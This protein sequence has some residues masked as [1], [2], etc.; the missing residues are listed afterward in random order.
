MKQ[1]KRICPSCHGSGGEVDVILED[2]TGPWEECGFCK[3][4]G[5]ITK[6]RLYYQALCWLSVEAKAR[7]K[8]K[9]VE[10]ALNS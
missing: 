1:W 10:Y 2:G 3:G 7:A 4:K 8:H 5:I 9:R 6:E